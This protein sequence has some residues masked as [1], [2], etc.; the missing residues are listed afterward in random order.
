MTTLA[1][2]YH[3]PHHSGPW[4][5]WLAVPALIAVV[6]MVAGVAWLLRNGK[7]I[8]AQSDEQLRILR[9]SGTTDDL[10]V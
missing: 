9:A 8:A 5:W 3:S 10:D 7:R 4:P 2:Y 1:E 6:A